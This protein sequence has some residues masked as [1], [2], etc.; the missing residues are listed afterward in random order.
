MQKKVDFLPAALSSTTG[1][2]LLFLSSFVGGITRIVFFGVLAFSSSSDS[3]SLEN[4]ILE[5]SD[6]TGT[7][8]GAGTTVPAGTEEVPVPIVVFTVCSLFDEGV[9]KI[10]IFDRILST[11]GEKMWDFQV[12]KEHS[13]GSSRAKIFLC[14]APRPRNENFSAL[15][16]EQV[17]LARLLIYHPKLKKFN[18]KSQE[19]M[20]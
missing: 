19:L 5:S 1:K 7:G 13:G 4:S 8:T 11:N 9:E 17:T 6:A 12:G 10:F 14:F 2:T 18:F 3:E 16:I 15:G 20:R